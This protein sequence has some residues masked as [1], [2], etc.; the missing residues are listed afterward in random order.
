[1]ENEEENFEDEVLEELDEDDEAEAF[2]RQASK[3]KVKPSSNDSNAVT[4]P[5][6]V[7]PVSTPPKKSNEETGSW[8]H[9]VINAE[10]G[11]VN[12]STNQRLSSVYDILAQLANDIDKIKRSLK[13]D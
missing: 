5:A 6:Q 13:V 10:E 12:P 11:L 2:I 9:Y 1:M 4:K 3:K 8:V 7:K